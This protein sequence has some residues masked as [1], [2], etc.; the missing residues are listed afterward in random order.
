MKKA[1][2]IAAMSFGAVV[3]VWAA[4]RLVI[5]LFDGMDYFTGLTQPVALGICGFVAM[6][7]SVLAYRWAR[8]RFEKRAVLVIR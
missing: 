3:A 2:G 8:R 7:S 1:F 5:T 6:L 4:A